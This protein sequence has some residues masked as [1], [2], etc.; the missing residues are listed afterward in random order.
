MDTANSSVSRYNDED[1]AMFKELLERKLEKAEN[2]KTFLLEQIQ[3]I[4]ENEDG[5]VDWMDDT[6]T[7]SD[8]EMLYAQASRLNHNIRDIRNA[9]VRI[10]NR[11]YGIC[12]VSGKLIDRRRLMAVP[13]TTKSLE[14][15][16]MIATEAEKSER[17]AYTPKTTSTPT[18]R[19]IIS[20]IISKPVP[21]P[22]V[23]SEQEEDLDEDE[24]DF[25]DEDMILD[26]DVIDEEA[27]SDD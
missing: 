25:L 4:T 22:P 26:F 27:D 6:S 11:S 2:E 17:Q 24:D 1:L 20:K 15:K 5:D 12:V 21:K 16:N 3:S 14:A 8:L 9:L 18:E 19:K 10:H 23:P 7:S 13:T